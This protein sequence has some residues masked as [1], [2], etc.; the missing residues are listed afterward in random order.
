MT[1]RAYLQSRNLAPA[2]VTAYERVI[3][4]TVTIVDIIR[5]VP[6]PIPVLIGHGTNVA[7][8]RHWNRYTLY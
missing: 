8:I 5:D 3:I 4:L 2:T 7:A 6:Q 1:F